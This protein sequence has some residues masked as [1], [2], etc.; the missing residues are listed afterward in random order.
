MS[1]IP[2]CYMASVSVRHQRMVLT[3]RKIF[4]GGPPRFKT[5]EKNCRGLDVYTTWIYACIA[6]TDRNSL[7]PYK[8]A[9]FSSFSKSL[10]ELADW[11]ASY[12]CTD[13]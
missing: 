6:I 9:L 8:K 4:M 3:V 12:S 2:H 13:V 5:S 1:L 10:W 7:T 11:L